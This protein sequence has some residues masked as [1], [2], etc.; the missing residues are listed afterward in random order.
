M[1]GYISPWTHTGALVM[2]NYVSQRLCFELKAVLLDDRVMQ[3][4]A[5]DAINFGIDGGLVDQGGGRG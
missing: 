2:M 3:D 1:S 4:L 5:C